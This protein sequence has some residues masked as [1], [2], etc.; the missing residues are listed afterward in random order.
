MSTNSSADRHHSHS[1]ADHNRI[2]L[3][4]LSRLLRA[5]QLNDLQPQ[6]SQVNIAI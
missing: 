6:L 1:L 4:L 5:L 2:S 3:V